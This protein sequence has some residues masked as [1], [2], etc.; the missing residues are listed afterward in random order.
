MEEIEFLLDE[1]KESM[2]KSIQHTANELGKIRAGKAMPSMLNGIRADYYGTPTEISQM[3]TI[4]TPDARSITIKPWE[5][6]VIA[7]IE[8]A[9]NDSDLGIVPQNDGELIRLSIPILTE[10]RRKQ[11]VKQVKTETEK[12]RVSV[13]NVRKEINNELKAL[14]KEGASEDEVKVAEDKVQKMTDVHIKKIEDLFTAKEKDIMT[15]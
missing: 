6:S 15:L 3:A 11:L 13:R 1:A 9:I 12:G 14:Q 8:K 10:E 7:A 2:G 5:K 4:N